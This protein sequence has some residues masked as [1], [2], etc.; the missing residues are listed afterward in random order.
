M[1][2]DARGLDSAQSSER[3]MSVNEARM[4]SARKGR[5]LGKVRTTQYLPERCRVPGKWL[6][7]L[8]PSGDLF[9]TSALILVLAAAIS[10][11]ALHVI[12]NVYF[13]PLSR[14]PGPWYAAASSLTMA[15]I[16]VWRV[17]PEWLLRLT[18]NYGS[19]NFSKPFVS[20]VDA[21]Q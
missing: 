9:L 14:F 17:E 20:G 7:P 19:K 21:I 4:R 3:P 8:P 5:S 12:Y 13:H 16:S 15:L 2:N 6:K 11:L 1:R 10:T 18:Q